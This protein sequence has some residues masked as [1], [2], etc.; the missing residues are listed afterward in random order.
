MS[1][2]TQPQLIS[3]EICPFVQRA[4]VILN[5]KGAAC[6]VT[7][8]DLADKPD[9]FTDRVPTGRVPALFVGNDT[10]FESTVINE[11]LDETLSEPL[12]PD[13]PLARAKERAWI[14]FTDGLIMS[15]FRSLAA[16]T[17]EEFNTE[18]TAML[19][20]LS[21]MT[22]LMAARY[23]EEFNIG[24]LEAAIAPV[25]TRVS[26]VP[27]LKTA[28]EQRFHEGHPIRVWAEWLLD[29]PAVSQSVPDVFDARFKAFFEPKGSYA[30]SN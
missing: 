26:K 23:G 9:W 16:K 24:M 4:R 20:G 17:K 10:V 30:L 28:F 14:S 22:D 7:Y 12:L 29:Q 13:A 11:Y 3:F 21:S 8:I 25:F 19:D 2:S 18:C 15:Q 27:A 5:A 1:M 6:E